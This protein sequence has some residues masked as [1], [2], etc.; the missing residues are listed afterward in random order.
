MNLS[1]TG[2]YFD[3]RFANIT[4]DPGSSTP[5]AFVLAT[6]GLP[7]FRFG[8][9]SYAWEARRS[10]AGT[11]GLETT[12]GRFDTEL[13]RSE[14]HTVRLNM[15]L[16]R[17]VQLTTT[18]T[19]TRVRGSQYWSGFGGI[20]LVLGRSTTASA[21]HYRLPD[22]Q[23]TF[24]DVNRSRPI[25][26][27]IGY[28]LT[29]SD[30]GGGEAEGLIEL[31]TSINYAAVAYTVRNADPRANVTATLAGSVVATQGGLFFSRPI[32]GSSAVVEV[33]GLKNVRVLSDN[34][35]VGR[36]NSRGRVLIPRLLP[37][38]ANRI[39]VVEEDIPFDFEVP[40][41]SQ[42]VAP[43]Y[44]GAAHVVFRTARIQARSGS[45][46][47]VIAGVE[48][49]PS[50]GEIVVTV[51]ANLVGSPLNLAGEFFLDLPDGRHEATVTY[52][53]QSCTVQIDATTGHGLIQKVGVLRCSR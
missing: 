45:I 36:T 10:E 32:D 28:G 44:K 30:V 5:P 7:I 37:Y 19:S 41:R 15:R 3:R 35:P 9:I 1:V 49:V 40:Q 24:I 47:M 26:P 38:L 51:G 46:R 8:S 53:G 33:T 48:T 16:H 22:S 17:W 18:A 20:N 52:L 13:T 42:L 25:G 12:D 6:V 39:S 43:P 14:V 50:Y 21:T 4:L 23:H 11:F 29:A 2:Q 31:N 27:G 34:V